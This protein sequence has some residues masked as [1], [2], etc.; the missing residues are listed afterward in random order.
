MRAVP[1]GVAT[2][3]KPRARMYISAGPHQLL[4][5]IADKYR[6]HFAKPHEN[7]V[8]CSRIP[9]CLMNHVKC[10]PSDLARVSRGR[11]RT[12]LTS[13]KGGGSPKMTSPGKKPSPAARP[14]GNAACN[15]IKPCGWI[16]KH[17]LLLFSIIARLQ[18]GLSARDGN[19]PWEYSLLYDSS[20]QTSSSPSYK[21]RAHA[22]LFNFEAFEKQTQPPQLLWLP[23][24]F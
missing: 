22:I 16:E 21:A 3:H 6:A 9:L 24:K 10:D 19:T 13:E 4:D 18:S 1:P 2:G 17:C 15:P 7:F 20:H 12:R 11:D 8:R 5:P 23:N 14:S